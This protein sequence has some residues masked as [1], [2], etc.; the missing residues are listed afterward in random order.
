MTRNSTPDNKNNA[1]GRSGAAFLPWEARNKEVRGW[2]AYDIVWDTGG[3]PTDL[4]TTVFIT[5]ETGKDR[6]VKKNHRTLR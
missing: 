6:I 3:S 5:D 1:H 2:I 4:P